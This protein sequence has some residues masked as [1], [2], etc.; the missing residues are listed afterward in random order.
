MTG[1]VEVLKTAGRKFCSWVK[2]SKT[3]WGPI[4]GGRG[5]TL[6]TCFRK[7]FVSYRQGSM[8]IKVNVRR[9]SIQERHHGLFRGKLNTFSPMSSGAGLPDAGLRR[10]LDLPGPG[11]H[12]RAASRSDNPVQPKEA[13]KSRRGAMVVEGKPGTPIAVPFSPRS[14]LS[15]ASSSPPYP[16]PS[17]PSSSF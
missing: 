14:A 17:W 15:S 5:A 1:E 11:V 7:N 6:A 16:W 4:T 8:I 2:Y 3:G 10:Q 12:A 13:K 9:F